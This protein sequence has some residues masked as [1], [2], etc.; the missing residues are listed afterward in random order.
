MKKEI[1][2]SL[3]GS[4]AALGRALKMT[5]G[6]IH[7]W[8]DELPQRCADRVIGAALRLGKITP[9]EAKRLCELEN[10]ERKTGPLRPPDTSRKKDG[11]ND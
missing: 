4:G 3:F 9:E 6:A 8:P 11:K 2:I 5:R 1:V 10:T 7:N